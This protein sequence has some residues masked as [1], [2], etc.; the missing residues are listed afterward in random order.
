MPVTPICCAKRSTG[1]PASSRRYT[2]TTFGMTVARRPLIEEPQ[3][4]GNRQM[5]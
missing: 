5:V 1:P 4:E 2:L 3:T